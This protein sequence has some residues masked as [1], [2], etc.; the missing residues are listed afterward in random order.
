MPKLMSTRMMILICNGWT[1]QI[2][3]FELLARNQNDSESKK[4][5]R[6]ERRPQ[7]K[8]SAKWWTPAFALRQLGWRGFSPLSALSDFG[9][10][11]IGIMS[12]AFRTPVLFEAC[13]LSSSTIAPLRASAPSDPQFSQIFSVH[14]VNADDTTVP[15]PLA[16]RYLIDRSRLTFIPD[17][18][19][20]SG[21]TYRAVLRVL[22]E[23]ASAG[24]LSR[25]VIHRDIRPQDRSSSAEP[26]RSVD[27][28]V[29]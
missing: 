5:S 23:D 7:M 6:I 17:Q 13:G 10:P 29:N 27:V 11:R 2:C 9:E 24:D 15:A 8:Q 12:D 26:I 28:S 18:P 1:D 21:Q 16:G 14:A 3:Q 25:F 4:L 19:L 20:Q 22:N